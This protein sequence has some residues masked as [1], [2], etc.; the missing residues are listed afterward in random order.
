M[1]RLNQTSIN[2]FVRCKYI[3]EISIVLCWALLDYSTTLYCTQSATFYNMMW[4]P[5]LQLMWQITDDW[6]LVCFVKDSFLSGWNNNIFG[7]LIGHKIIIIILMGDYIIVTAV[8]EIQYCCT[9]IANN[10]GSVYW[11]FSMW[12]I[13]ILFQSH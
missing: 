13:L 9:E 10:H 12:I 1:I 3:F 2:S 5:Q 4:R 7:D 11:L 6:L 8:I